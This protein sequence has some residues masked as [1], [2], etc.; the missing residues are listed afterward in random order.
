MSFFAKFAPFATKWLVRGS[1]WPASNQ[2]ISHRLGSL[3]P[4]RLGRAFIERDALLICASRYSA[5]FAMI[6]GA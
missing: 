6:T 1:L 2:T 4:P 3:Q 5:A